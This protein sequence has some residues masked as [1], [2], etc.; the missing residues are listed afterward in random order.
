MK[1]PRLPKVY[2]TRALTYDNATWRVDTNGY[3]MVMVL[4]DCANLEDCSS[5]YGPVPEEAMRSACGDDARRIRVDALRSF[6]G[7][8]QATSVQT[9]PEC[10]GTKKVDH[11]CDCDYCT[12]KDEDCETCEDGKVQDEPTARDVRIRDGVFD[13]NLLG[14]LL[15]NVCAHPDDLIYVTSHGPDQIVLAGNGWRATA[16]AMRVDK[17][18][19]VPELDL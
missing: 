17:S 9:C 15:E 6:L 13:A 4:G 7:E 2:P 10:K 1:W 16:M 18:A 19:K 8:P 11:D 5:A 3:G 14:C 12:V